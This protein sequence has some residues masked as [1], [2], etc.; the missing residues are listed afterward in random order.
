MFASLAIDSLFFIFPVRSMRHMVWHINP[1]NNRFILGSVVLGALMI[2]VPVYFRPFQI[3]LKTVPLGWEE[4]SVVLVF[5]LLNV[6]IIEVVK[7]IFLVK[8]YHKLT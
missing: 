1:F 6:A 8:K 2:A 3:L 5:G 7:G 4:W